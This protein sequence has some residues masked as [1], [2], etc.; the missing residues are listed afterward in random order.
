VEAVGHSRHHPPRTKAPRRQRSDDPSPTAPAKITPLE[1][2][3]PCPPRMSR[4]GWRARCPGGS[5]CAD[6]GARSRTPPASSPRPGHPVTHARMPR[7]PPPPAARPGPLRDRMPPRASVGR[8]ACGER[9][10]RRRAS[11]SSGRRRC[12][13]LSRRVDG[14]V[15]RTVGPCSV[16]GFANALRAHRRGFGRSSKRARAGGMTGYF[17]VPP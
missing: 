10:I 9:V 17:A 11:S 3:A 14:S 4:G 1:K 16:V 5:G 8:D 13:I 7:P 15:L 6:A 12:R 2:N